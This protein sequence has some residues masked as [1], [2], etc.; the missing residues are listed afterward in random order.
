MEE[1]KKEETQKIALSALA[2]RTKSNE[3]AMSL[4]SS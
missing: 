1:T 2:E 4:E 3:L